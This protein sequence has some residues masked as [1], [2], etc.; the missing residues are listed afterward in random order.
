MFELRIHPRKTALF[1][2]TI[3]ILLTVLHSI[4]LTTFFLT[5]D[6][7]LLEI[8]EY[9]DLDIEKNI[10]S[11]YSAFALFFCSLIFFCISWLE[12]NQGRMRCYWLGLATIFLFL[13]LD[14]AFIIHEGLGDY[15][16]KHIKTSG[17]LQ[18]TGLLYFPW[19][20][21][22]MVL[23]SILGLLYFRFIFNLPRKTTILLVSSAII[24]LTGAVFFDMLGGKEAELHGY[25]SITY[26][27]LYT[28]EEFLEMIGVVL[29]IYTLLD[30]IKQKFGTLCLSLEVKKP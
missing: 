8:T 6:Q 12:K 21:P 29:L 7:S 10:P 5:D 11:F 14:E 19:V 15:T 23:T 20:L 30:Y 22:Y 13:S 17:L 9:V 3:V 28:L 18:A 16:E 2:L 27:V 1:F 24:F 25:Y 4:A 26:T